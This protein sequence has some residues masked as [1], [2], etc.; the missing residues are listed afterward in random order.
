MQALFKF[1]VLTI[2]DKGLYTV[3][4]ESQFRE[5]DDFIYI[6]GRV[7]QFAF[8]CYLCSIWMRVKKTSDYK[9]GITVSPY[10]RLA[11]KS[12]K[13]H[14]YYYFGQKGTLTKSNQK[15][16]CVQKFSML[17]W[18]FVFSRSRSFRKT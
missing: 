8:Q 16:E 4:C 7:I 1:F 10:F 6:I 12:K 15:V 13:R 2:Y 3:S 11:R 17:T 5:Y 18:I 14:Y 9:P